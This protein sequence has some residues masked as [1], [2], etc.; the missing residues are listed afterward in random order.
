MVFLRVKCDDCGVYAED[1]PV[2][3]AGYMGDLALRLRMMGWFLK[4]EHGLELC[5]ECAKQLNEP[6]LHIEEGGGL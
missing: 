2:V 1:F 4:E 3:K 6:V 5:P